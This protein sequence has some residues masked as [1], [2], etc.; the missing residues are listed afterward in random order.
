MNRVSVQRNILENT[1]KELAAWLAGKG[2]KS[3]HLD[4]I[5][6]WLYQ[7]QASAFDQMTDISKALRALLAQDFSI[8]RLK[9]VKT[10]ASS[11]GAKKFLYELA[12]GNCI[13]SVLLP[14]KG[15]YTLCVS[16]QVG[17]AM[18]CA[19]CRTGRD[20]FIRNLT[21]GE[22]VCQVRD[23]ALALENPESL[24][25]LVFM[26]MGEPLA[27]YENLIAALDILTDNDW[28]MRFSGRRVTVSTAGL[29]PQIPLLGKDSRVK[30]A[31]SL[32]AADDATRDA[33]MPI[34]KKWP[35]KELLAACRAFPL[36]AG[37][38]VT[39]EF[40]LL[41][42]INDSIAHAKKLAALLG[43]FPCKI[44][45]IAYNPHD[46]SDFER[47]E[48]QTL[49]AFQDVLL[50]KHFTVIIRDSKGGDIAAACGQLRGGAGPGKR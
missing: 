28:G 43:G 31:V 11:D 39:F 46:Q 37:R 2:Q 19:F 15:H 24:T 30:L 45:L 34:N 12:D 50:Q 49:L 18:N 10:A 21:L 13:E 48:E 16:S 41:K 35:I 17:C 42:G 23:T 1:P 26:G 5:L 9:L 33:I 40:V 20:G 3:F 32:N 6:R 22:I 27:N 44:N 14:E 47:P 8:D 4:Q 36:K 38:R 29:V 25:N 7:R